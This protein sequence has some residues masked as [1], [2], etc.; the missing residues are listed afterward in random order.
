MES[1]KFFRYWA[2]KYLRSASLKDDPVVIAELT[3]MA[4]D[5]KTWVDEAEVD[6][7]SYAGVDH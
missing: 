6:G 7:N 2:E 4:R 3:A 1:P 5:L